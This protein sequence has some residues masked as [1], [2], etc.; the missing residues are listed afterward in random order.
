MPGGVV[1]DILGMPADLPDDSGAADTTG[2]YVVPPGHYFGMGDSR[3]NSADSRFLDRLGFIPAE[4]LIG[5]AEFRL[6]SMEPGA[7]L[8]QV[9]RWPTAMRISRFFGLVR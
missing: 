9:W 3:D 8:W 7:H 4:N 5:R 1:H 2:V 6:I